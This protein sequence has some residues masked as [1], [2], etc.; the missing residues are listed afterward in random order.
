MTENPKVSALPMMEDALPAV[1]AEVFVM[2][3]SISQQRYWLLE[4]LS[5]GNTALNI[6]LAVQLSGP[7][8]AAILESAL[9]AIVQR[10]EVLRTSFALVEGAPKQ[11]IQ[12]D[13]VLKLG[14]ID[15]RDV[16]PEKRQARIEQEMI[17]EA[18][19]PLSLTEAP[20]FRTTLLRLTPE[21]NVLMLTIHHIVGDGWSNGLL[22]REVGLFYRAQL[23]GKEADLPPLTVHYADYALWQEEWLKTPQFERQL[24][25]W[26]ETLDGEPPVLDMPTDYPRE[27]GLTSYTAYIESLL[28]PMPLGDAI[29]RLCIDLDVTLFMV[30]FATYVTLLHRYTGQTEFMIGTTAANRNRSELEHLI[31]LF[32]N[33]LI[34]RPKISEDMTFRELAIRLRDHS[35][36]GFAHQEV[37]F[38]MVLEQ[39]QERKSVARKPMIQ[40]HFLYQ[41]AFME[42]ATYGDLTIRPLRSVSPG[43]T[44]ELTYGI[45]ERAEGIRLQ[46]EYHTALYKKSTIRRMLRHFESLLEAAVENPDTPIS[47]MAMLT[48]E[49][50]ASLEPLWTTR[51]PLTDGTRTGVDP[52]AVLQDFRVQLKKHFREAVYPHGFSIEPL[53]SETLVVLDRHLHLLPV[54]IPGTLYLGGI[55][56]E[57][58]VDYVLVHGP[59]DVLSPMPLLRTDFVGQ[60]CVDGKI[61]LIGKSDDFARINGFRV[62]LRQVEAFMLHHPGVQ[63]VA[64]AAFRQASGEFQLTLYIL[65]KPGVTPTEKEL[66]L[67]LKGK[68][69]DFTMPTHIVMVSV[70]PKDVNGEVVSELLPEPVP[71]PLAPRDE[72]IPLEAILYHQLIEIWMEILRVPNLTIEDNFFA[73]GGSSLLALRMMTQIEKLCGRPLPLSLLLT[74]ATIANLAHYIVQANNE[75]A[76]P[77]IAINS[78]GTRPPLFFLHG[79][80]AGGGFYCGRLS[81]QLGE[82]QPFYV[83]PPYRSGKQNVFTLE[84]MAAYH[85]AA[86]QE[87]SPHGPYLLGGYC[88]GATIAI[89]MAR[90]LVAKGERVTHLLLIDPLSGTPWLR[91]AWPIV[92][93]VGEFQKWDLQKKIHY[94]DR[95]AVSL[96]R[97]LNKPWR[98]KITTLLRRLGLS[99]PV[100]SSSITAN[101]E[102][103][104]GVEILT[105]LDY[106]VYFLA[107]RLYR[108]KP[109]SVPATLYFPEETPPARLSWVKRASERAPARFTVEFLPGDHHTCITKYTPALVA[110]M[111]TALNSL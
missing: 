22:V 2:P 31:G 42:P 9:N 79:D 80:W 4:Q 60:N 110:K 84:E 93:G 53:P 49:E 101:R 28:L 69:S 102:A 17:A 41:K 50:R 97:W 68:I 105:H 109:L 37:P 92:D 87:R 13:V 104:E 70:L 43:S 77:L 63:E 67:F 107:Y 90:Q 52:K 103:G 65:P 23:K 66:R 7:L 32:A 10:H 44:F 3:C 55:A 30:L 12:S 86:M 64:A 40:T 72:K 19:R 78:K 85:I 6:P 73:L 98:S 47:E 56:P 48:E 108:S 21:E 15:L 100:A 82:D 16:P 106:A 25:Y 36:N 83:L 27:L 46:M 24:A 39:L 14:E 38:E 81:Q 58:A 57:A 11:V 91:L 76:E 35:L 34:L 29:K 59:L 95:Y 8:D 71:P 88:I 20:I 111:K 61:E 75:S 1:E 62:N 33:P 54:G 45:V 5:P 51:G 96:A 18:V 26:T 89:E 99:K 74:G 94:F